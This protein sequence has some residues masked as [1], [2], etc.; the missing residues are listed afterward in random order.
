MSETIE[1][2]NYKD[3]K[4]EKSKYKIINFNGVDIKVYQYIMAQDMLDL[5]NSVLQKSRENGYFSPFKVDLYTH[6]NIVYLVTDIVFS[7]EDREDELAL[8]DQL[9]SSGLMQ[10]IINALPANYYQSILSFVEETINRIQDYN[11][12]TA[13]VLNALIQDLPQNA[14]AAMNFVNSFDPNKYEA[15]KKFAEAANGGRNI[16]TN[17]PVPAPVEPVKKKPIIIKK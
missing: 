16:S 6:L 14:E 5:I 17:L 4:V 7:Q 10:M 11:K 3:I 9:E 13:A 15:V 8:Y 2:L 12:T 1:I